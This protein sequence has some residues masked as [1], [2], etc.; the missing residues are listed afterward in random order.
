MT[1]QKV[2]LIPYRVMYKVIQMHHKKIQPKCYTIHMITQ[3]VPLTLTWSCTR[4]SR[5]T[6]E[7][8]SQNATQPI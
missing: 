6:N 8:L 7:K 2:P 5:C 3:K 4:S 1:T